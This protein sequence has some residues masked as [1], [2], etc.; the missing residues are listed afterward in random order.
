[1]R[2]AQP[3]CF[4]RLSSRLDPFEAAQDPDAV[5]RLGDEIAEVQV[6]GLDPPRR[7]R[8]KSVF[9]LPCSAAKNVSRGHQ[10]QPGVF[11]DK[12]LLQVSLED[13]QCTGTL[14]W[15]IIPAG[16]DL[17]LAFQDALGSTGKF[18]KIAIGG[19]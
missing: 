6:G 9:G 2:V 13:E 19:C 4:P 15:D 8:W 10:R 1:M 14:A 3:N 5:V 7:Y 11:V 16:D 12:A 18:G 17:G